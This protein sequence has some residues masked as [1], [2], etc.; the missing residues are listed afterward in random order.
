L[1]LLALLRLIDYNISTIFIDGTDEMNV[2]KTV[3]Y[4][5]IIYRIFFS[6]SFLFIQFLIL[7]KYK[8]I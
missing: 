8:I 7:N 3:T 2:A 4:K 6:K 1:L 5:K